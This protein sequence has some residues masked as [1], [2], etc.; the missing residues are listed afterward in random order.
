MGSKGLTDGDKGVPNQG[1]KGELGLEDKGSAS[2]VYHSEKGAP[3]P[4]R[5]SRKSDQLLHDVMSGPQM[6][7]DD[8][9]SS[10]DVL[11][12]V[13]GGDLGDVNLEELGSD[14]WA[15]LSANS[16]LPMI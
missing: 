8:K 11:S 9:G 1:D 5:V 2:E 15:A 7:R 16:G 10:A 14:T 4:V 3:G 12:R 13:L 6:S